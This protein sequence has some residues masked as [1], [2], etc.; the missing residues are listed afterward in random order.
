MKIS[1]DFIKTDVDLKNDG[2]KFTP[3]CGLA[4]N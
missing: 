3:L 1:T 2:F 4:L